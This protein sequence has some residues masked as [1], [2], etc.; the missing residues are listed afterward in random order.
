MTNKI[1]QELKDKLHATLDAEISE[2]TMK[3]IKKAVDGI[4]TDI[5]G[6]VEYRLKSDLA[7]NLTSWVAECAE[8]AV[9]ALLAGNDAMMRLYLRC[10]GYYDG[11]STGLYGE[12]QIERAHEVI[13][14]KLWE[15]G[16]IELR[17]KIVEAHRDLLVNERILDLED[18]VKSL[19]AQVNKANAEKEELRDRFRNYR[20]EV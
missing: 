20:V 16:P 7:M 8:R 15:G 2:A 10:D 5:E 17:K 3:G 19:V 12:K 9:D 1:D 6:D 4:L 11:R 18:Q 13:H 14:G